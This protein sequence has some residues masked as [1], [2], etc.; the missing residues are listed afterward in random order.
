MIKLM[1]SRQV[2]YCLLII[3]IMENKGDAKTAHIRLDIATYKHHTTFKLILY[4]YWV[5]YL[6]K[7]WII[8]IVTVKSQA[9]ITI[10]SSKNNIIGLSW[11]QNRLSISRR[12]LLLMYALNNSRASI[13]T[14]VLNNLSDRLSR[15]L[16]IIVHFFFLMLNFFEFSVKI[17]TPLAQILKT[18]QFMSY[19]DYQTVGVIG[20]CL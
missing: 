8:I 3:V 2:T 7:P 5:Q 10:N 1:S 18:K 14:R 17:Q 9:M 16:L 11:I 20:W 15:L 6:Y 4:V 13:T 19:V 12:N